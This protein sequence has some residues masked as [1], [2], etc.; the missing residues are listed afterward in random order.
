MASYTMAK[1]GYPSE[2][3]YKDMLCSNMITHSPLT[4]ADIDATNNILRCNISSLN[5][6]TPRRHPP[7]VLSDYMAVPIKIK[8]ITQRLTIS[9]DVLFVIRLAFLVSVSC[10]LKLM[11]VEYIPKHTG[12][13]LSKYIDKVYDIYLRCGFT[14]KLLLMDR[15]FEC[16]CD[17]IP[18]YSDLNTTAAKIASVRH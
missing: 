5:E 17:N 16:L 4:P 2:A 10:S 13:V 7:R 15:E 11:K 12:T 9:E 18:W 6:K 14:V 1:L 8:D 3:D